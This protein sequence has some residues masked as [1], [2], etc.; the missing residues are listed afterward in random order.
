MIYFKF[1][2]IKNIY[3]Q[4]GIAILFLDNNEDSSSKMEGEIE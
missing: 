2:F 4:H 3:L 1:L